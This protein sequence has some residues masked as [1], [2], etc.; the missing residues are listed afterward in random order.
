MFAP[1]VSRFATYAIEVSDTSH[2]YMDKILTLPSMQR[3]YADAADE[4]HVIA[5]SEAGTDRD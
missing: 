5:A 4:P 1:V 2:A 3:W